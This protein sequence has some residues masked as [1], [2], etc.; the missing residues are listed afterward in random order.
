MNSTLR[1]HDE[2]LRERVF[3][4][5]TKWPHF[6]LLLADLAELSD[7]LPLAATVV[8]LE[9]GLLY[10]GHSLLGPYFHRQKLISIDCSP[11]SA[12][13]RGGYNSHMVDDDR[14]IRIPISK[15]ASVLATGLEVECADL[16]VVP[17]LVHHVADQ[18]AL[19]KEVAR[20][21]KPGGTAYVFEP[22]VRELHQAPDDY[23]RYTPYGLSQIMTHHGLTPQTI[24]QEGGPFSAV[25]YCWTQA[26]EYFPNETRA[27]MNE[28]FY[29]AH[30]KQ[31]LQ[32]DREFTKNLL[33][34]HTS[35]P[36]AFSLL[37]IKKRNN[38]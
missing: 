28:W 6:K 23:L 11:P 30:F 18:Q 12:D 7:K 10:G 9:R 16:V 26:L 24:K 31:L 22:L 33:R 38:E 1:K 13:A 35:F 8:I 34:E 15:R 20:V 29:Q 2:L 3:Q 19:F 4:V 37:G 21:L 14:F 32:W 5:E 27:E 25:A 17:N 36:M